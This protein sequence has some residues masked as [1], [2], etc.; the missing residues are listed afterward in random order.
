MVLHIRAGSTEPSLPKAAGSISLVS[1]LSFKVSVTATSARPSHRRHH[2][3]AITTYVI[4]LC[5]ISFALSALL[6]ARS[7]SAWH[8]QLLGKSHSSE[9]PSIPLAPPQCVLRF[10]FDITCLVLQGVVGI[11]S[12]T[13][14]FAFAGVYA[15]YSCHLISSVGL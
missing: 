4:S 13:G 5:A 9:L 10:L 7:L 15:Y 8:S 12:A 6:L 11:H 14:N 2:H 1:E 3:R